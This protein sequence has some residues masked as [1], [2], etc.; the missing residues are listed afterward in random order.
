MDWKAAAEKMGKEGR[1][2]GA[3]EALERHGLAEETDRAGKYK[4]SGPRDMIVMLSGQK[5]FDFRDYSGGA[6]PVSLISAALGVEPPKAAEWLAGQSP[7]FAEIA[8]KLEAAK[9]AGAA[10]PAAVERGRKPGL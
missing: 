2:L 9:V 7:E 5:W 8:A 1:I 3:I 4:V 6:G 10:E